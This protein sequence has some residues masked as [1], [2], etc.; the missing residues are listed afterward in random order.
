MRLCL[1]TYKCHVVCR[2]RHLLN[3]HDY[4]SQSKSAYGNRLRKYLTMNFQKEPSSQTTL[5]FLNN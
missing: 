2:H 5:P 1:V 3:E 4:S